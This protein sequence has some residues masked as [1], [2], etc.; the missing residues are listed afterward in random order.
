MSERSIVLG[1][2]ITSS[3]GIFKSLSTL[4]EEINLLPGIPLLSI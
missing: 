1:V 2:S 4:L 3:L